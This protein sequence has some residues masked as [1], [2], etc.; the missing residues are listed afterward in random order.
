M[1][2]FASCTLRGVHS[3]RAVASP[4]LL[5]VRGLLRSTGQDVEN[6]GSKSVGPAGAFRS[7]TTGVAGFVGEHK[8]EYAFRSTLGDEIQLLRRSAPL[9]TPR[10]DVG[11]VLTGSP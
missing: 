3:R 4:A 7:T 1:V 5:R 9:P 2:C 11:V 6:L 8:P 10:R